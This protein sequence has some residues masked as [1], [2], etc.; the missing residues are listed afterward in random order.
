MENK[1]KDKKSSPK[2]ISVAEKPSGSRF[3]LFLGDTAIGMVHLA[4]RRKCST[5]LRESASPSSSPS[6][7]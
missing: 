1:N 5:S 6:S 4:L 3:P 7:P 2:N